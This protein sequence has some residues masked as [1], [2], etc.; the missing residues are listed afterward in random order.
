MTKKLSFFRINVAALVANEVK[1][2]VEVKSDSIYEAQVRWLR[3]R[4]PGSARS[5]IEIKV[6]L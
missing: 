3:L 6:L 4:T 2:T 1:H 5:K